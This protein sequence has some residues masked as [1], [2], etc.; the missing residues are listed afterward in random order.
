MSIDNDVAYFAQREKAER[1][2]AE[3]SRDPATRCIHRTM[4]ATYRQRLEVM[5]TQQRKAVGA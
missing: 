3:Q 1:E 4:A 5:Q 2:L